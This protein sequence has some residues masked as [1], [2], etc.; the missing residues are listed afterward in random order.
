M[1]MFVN[2][3][4]LS[5]LRQ[6][7]S[8]LPEY[9]QTDNQVVGKHWV[10]CAYTMGPSYCS[11]GCSHCY[12]PKD[13]NRVPLVTLAEMKQQIDAN[14]KLIG[15]GGRIQITGGDVVDAYIKAN[16]QS[17]LIEVIRYTVDQGLVPMLMTHG[18]SLLDNPT[19]LHDLILQGGLRKLS[20]HVDMTQAGRKNYPLKQ[21]SRERDL[22]PVRDQIVDMLVQAR[23]ITGKRVTG[24]HTVT[25]CDANIESIGDILDWIISNPQNMD[26]TRTISFQTEADVGRTLYQSNRA[27]PE[28]V[29]HKIEQSV[30]MNLCRDQLIFGHPDCTSTATLLARSQDRKI[31][32]LSGNSTPLKTFRYSIL[33]L[34]SGW[35]LSENKLIHARVLRAIAILKKPTIITQTL[36]FGRALF[37][38]HNLTFSMLFALLAGKAS[39]FNI[40]MHNF[41]DAEEAAKP[42]CQTTQDRLDACSFRGAVQRD[43]QWVAVPMCEVNSSIRPKLYEQRRKSQ[44]IASV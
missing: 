21:I 23:K 13:A 25:V 11:F 44:A 9:L 5:L 28:K 17:E 33:S 35:N 12:L 27:T 34:C 4:T 2:S 31:V 42:S 32:N 6:R 40:V 22:N 14:R 37:K 19:L 7:W 29:W 20:F 30:G 43:G 15:Y 1:V 26:F 38:Y 41:I 24:A 18:Q 8:E 3:E 16:K 10:Q 39:G 36:G